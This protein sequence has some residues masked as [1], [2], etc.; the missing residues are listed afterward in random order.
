[1]KSNE[2][3]PVP[4]VLLRELRAKF[5]DTVK[6]LE[7]ENALFHSQG[8][9]SVIQFLQAQFNKQNPDMKE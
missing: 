2:F 3:P 5:P 8:A 6:G 9:Q 4:A 1:M 7:G